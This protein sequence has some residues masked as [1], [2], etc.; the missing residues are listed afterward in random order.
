M[1]NE[2]TVVVQFVTRMGMFQKSMNAIQGKVKEVSK[3][4]IQYGKVIDLPMEKFKKF[5]PIISEVGNKYMRSANNLRLLTHG[6][7]GFKMEAL[8]V[9]FFGMM[10]QRTFMGLL[11]PVME[12]FGVFDL[13]RLMLLVLFLPIMELLFPYLLAVMEWFMNLP[14]PVKMALGVLVLLLA[15][16]GAILFVIGTLA[17]GIGA[18]VMMFG[19]SWVIIGVIVAA[20]LAIMTALFLEFIF[21]IISNWNKI[22]IFTKSLW[23]GIKTFFSDTFSAIGGFFKTWFLDKPKEWLNSLWDYVSNIFNKIAS[24]ISNSVIGKAFTFVGSTVQKLLGSREGG[25][26]IPQTGPYLLHQGEEVIP[27]GKVGSG[28]QTNIT[29]NFNGFTMDDLR[30]E[31]DNRDR[32]LVDDMRRLVKE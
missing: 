28:G 7:R 26:M 5:S 12:A 9:M 29:N 14:E 13:F 8:G 20:A 16:F 10:L 25:G 32:R 30:R 19:A 3:G 22:G 21:L 1:V 17:L 15:I 24:K 27:K 23:T 6:M 31:L 4:M 11:Q 18:L 2:E